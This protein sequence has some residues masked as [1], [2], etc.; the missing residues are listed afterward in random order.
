LVELDPKADL[1]VDLI[2]GSERMSGFSPVAF[3]RPEEAP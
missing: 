2:G 3:S 1:D